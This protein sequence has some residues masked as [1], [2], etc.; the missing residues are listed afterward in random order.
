MN[1]IKKSRKKF[2]Y[3]TPEF[4][5]VDTAYELN[6][7]LS[8]SAWRRTAKNLLNILLDISRLGDSLKIR[9]EK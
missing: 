9:V 1:Q 2:N 4:S 8:K 3:L 6:L 7:A 5:R